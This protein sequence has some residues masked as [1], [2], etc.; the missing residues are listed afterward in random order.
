MRILGG[1]IGGHTTEL[2]LFEGESP[3]ELTITRRQRF[4]SAGFS[5]LVG[6]IGEFMHGVR[7]DAASFG[8]DAVVQGSLLHAPSL[9]WGVELGP[10]A[11]VL[12]TP[13]CSLL[14]DLQAAAMGVLE[15]DPTRTSWLQKAPVDRDAPLALVSVGERYG[16]GLCLLP[17]RSW[18]SA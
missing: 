10:L 15:T 7:V 16:L 6:V 5:G 3:G 9:P 1:E 12:G 17:D 13:R 11:S 18:P 8:L 4:E 14:N 2:A